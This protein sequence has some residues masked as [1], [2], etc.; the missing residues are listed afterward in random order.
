MQT[1]KVNS[2]GVS[3][4]LYIDLLFISPHPLELSLNIEGILYLFINKVS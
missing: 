2:S 3:I 4:Y 1:Y